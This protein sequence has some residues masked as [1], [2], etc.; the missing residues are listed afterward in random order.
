[1]TPAVTIEMVLEPPPAPPATIGIHDK[2]P[3]W[4]ELKTDVPVAPDIGAA[5]GSTYVVFP[6]E[7]GAL[8]P[9]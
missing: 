5:E 9:I 1:M 2:I 8:I 6:A 4:S 3:V 7:A